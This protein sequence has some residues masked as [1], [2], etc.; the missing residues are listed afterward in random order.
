[1]LLRQITLENLLSFRKTTVELRGLNVLIGANAVGKSNLVEAIGLLQAAPTDLS[2]AIRRLGG[3]RVVCS[4]AGP[5]YS[6]IAAIECSGI[7]GEALR[8][9]LEFSEEARGFIILKERFGSAHLDVGDGNDVPYFERVAGNVRFGAESSPVPPTQSVFQVYKSPADP[10]PIT[11]VGRELEAVRIYR[12]FRTTGDSQARVG[13]GVLSLSPPAWNRFLDDGGDNLALVLLDMDFKGVYNR[14]RAYLQRFCDRFTDLKVRLDGSIAK[15]YIEETGLLEPLVSWR[16]SDGTLKF[17]CL[18]AVLFDPDVAPL[19]CIEEPE[20]GL[21]PDAI[22]IIAEA[23]VEASERTQLIVTTHSEA[24]IDALSERPEDVL[25]AER[26]FE[27]GTQFRRLDRERLSSW[28]ERYSLGSL[29][30]KGEL[31]GTRW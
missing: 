25:V 23:L 27:N 4:L 29:W 5:N 22:Q 16:L 8:Y 21:H 31:G 12:E 9:R 17:L 18:L 28:L 20:V 6:P 30:R 26:D 11:R 1:M 2:T 19:I 15:T 14:I 10:T 24:L 3:V 13:A 7:C